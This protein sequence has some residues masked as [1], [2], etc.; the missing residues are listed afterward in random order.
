[1]AQTAVCFLDQYLS[2][3]TEPIAAVLA[4]AA[5]LARAR[6]DHLET[7]APIGS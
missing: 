3:A 1:M 7:R 2:L 6:P 5:D 4:Y